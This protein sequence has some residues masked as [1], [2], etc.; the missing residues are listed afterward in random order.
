[1]SSSPDAR[2]FSEGPNGALVPSYVGITGL[3]LL[4]ESVLEIDALRSTPMVGNFALTEDEI[5]GITSRNDLSKLCHPILIAQNRTPSFRTGDRTRPDGLD[6]LSQLQGLSNN[7]FQ[8]Q[9]ADQP[10]CWEQEAMERYGGRFSNFTA[11]PTVAYVPKTSESDKTAVV[12]PVGVLYSSYGMGNHPLM[13]HQPKYMS[14]RTDDGGTV[15]VDFSILGDG[16][17]VRASIVASLN[18]FSPC[19][20]TVGKAKIDCFITF[21]PLVTKEFFDMWDLTYGWAIQGSS[22]GASVA[23]AIRGL[24]PMLYTGYFAQ[25]GTADPATTQYPHQAYEPTQ[26]GYQ[27]TQNGLGRPLVVARN[28]ASGLRAGVKQSNM[29]ERVEDIGVKAAFALVHGVAIIMPYFADDTNLSVEDVLN[30]AK[31]KN[32]RYQGQYF[33]SQAFF[34]SESALDGT[35]YFKNVTPVLMAKTPFDITVLASFAYVAYRAPNMNNVYMKF[36]QEYS[37]NVVQH[38]KDRQDRQDQIVRNRKNA[39]TAEAFE[40]RQQEFKAQVNKKA[41]KAA[42][43]LAEVARAKEYGMEGTKALKQVAKLQG[44]R[45]MLKDWGHANVSQ[46][47]VKQLPGPNQ[48]QLLINDNYP[49]RQREQNVVL[50]NRYDPSVKAGRIKFLNSLTAANIR[51]MTK[52]QLEKK[53]NDAFGTSEAG[54]ANKNQFLLGHDLAGVVGINHQRQK[55]ADM[56]RESTKTSATIRPRSSNESWNNPGPTQPSGQSAGAALGGNKRQ[57]T[58]PVLD[59]FFGNDDGPTFQEEDD[60]DGDVLLPTRAGPSTQ[61]QTFNPGSQNNND[62]DK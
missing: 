8:Y 33:M 46:R 16:S 11:F 6:Y 23:A 13:H 61:G 38:V 40:K 42:T 45:E 57:T 49:V 55:L 19:Q 60:G 15:N 39:N 30:K 34:T 18:C 37:D 1:M 56:L 31:I 5:R 10:N 20:E 29:L 41:E 32:P 28:Q 62:D 12:V 27:L 59:D 43:S 53:L 52:E 58:K 24:P 50:Q 21:I 25:M 51:G 22:L 3:D 4:P 26:A 2:S 17:S 7:R 48:R 47:T 54:Q 36:S 9:L 44:K 14:V 35:D